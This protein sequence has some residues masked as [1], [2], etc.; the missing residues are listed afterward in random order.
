MTPVHGLG[1]DGFPP[2]PRFTEVKLMASER[3]K[4][5]YEY[6]ATGSGDFPLDM[7]SHDHCWPVDAANLMSPEKR[8]LRMRSH[9]RPSIE[10]WKS[11]GW[12]VDAS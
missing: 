4:A 2:K 10:R 12:S 1:W 8:S 9:Q 3:P 11:F 7:L 6:V 5:V